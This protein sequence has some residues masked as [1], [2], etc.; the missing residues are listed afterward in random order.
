MCETKVLIHQAPVDVW[1]SAPSRLQTDSNLSV[2]VGGGATAHASVNNRL[3]FRVEE[4]W[5]E[6]K[7]NCISELVFSK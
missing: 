4:G 5:C 1:L 2:E 3:T 7:F 6:A